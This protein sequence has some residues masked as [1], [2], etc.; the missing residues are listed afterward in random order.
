MWLCIFSRKR[1][2]ETFENAQRRKVKQVQPMWVCIV[3][4]NPFEDSF[5][6]TQR[7]K[8]KPTNWAIWKRKQCNENDTNFYQGLRSTAII[9]YFEIIWFLYCLASRRLS[10]FIFWKDSI[11]E[12]DI[13]Q[14]MQQQ[15]ILKLVRFIWLVWSGVIWNR[16]N[17]L[18][19]WIVELAASAL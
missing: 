13:I 11:L 3:S 19:T 1:F 14:L 2:E 7:G 9:K 16:V 12:T 8:V 4:G 10:M 15:C 17:S 6:N 5:E 18:C